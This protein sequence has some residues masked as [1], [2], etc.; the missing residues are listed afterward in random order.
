MGRAQETQFGCQLSLPQSPSA[1]CIHLECSQCFSLPLCPL[2]PGSKLP[3][4]APFSGIGPP[5]RFL[6]KLDF[7][8]HCCQRAQSE[9]C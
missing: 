7:T 8:P 5:A 3:P 6:V 2:F 4:P 1:S 9:G